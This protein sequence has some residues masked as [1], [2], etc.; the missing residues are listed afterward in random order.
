MDVLLT[1]ALS[2][3]VSGSLGSVTVNFANTPILISSPQG[4]FTLTVN[5]VVLTANGSELPIIG[6]IDV[7]SV[8]GNNVV[9][10]PS[11]LALLAIATLGLVRRL[12]RPAR[13]RSQR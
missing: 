6:R 11:S 8:P 3:A 13:T 10:E 2:G 5:D 4:V 12:A 1:A 9:P 7:V